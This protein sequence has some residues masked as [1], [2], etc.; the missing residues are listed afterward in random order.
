MHSVPLLPYTC[1]GP[2]V[3]KSDSGKHETSVAEKAVVLKKRSHLECTCFG[4]LLLA[5]S[6]RMSWEHSSGSRQKRPRAMADTKRQKHWPRITCQ[7]GLASGERR[8]RVHGCSCCRRGSITP[9]KKGTR[10]SGAGSTLQDSSRSVPVAPPWQCPVRTALAGRSVSRRLD[11][12]PRVIRNCCDS[13]WTRPL[14]QTASSFRVRQPGMQ[15]S[16]RI[17]DSTL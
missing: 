3:A 2:V 10:D 17:H 7:C 12:C 1:F 8:T 9:F 14:A 5:K 6:D 4:P 11:R 15:N 16:L 13:V